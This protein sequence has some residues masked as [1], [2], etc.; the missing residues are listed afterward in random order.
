VVDRRWGRKVKLVGG[1]DVCRFFEQVHQFREVEELRKARPCPVACSLRRKLNGGC[2][3]AK[4]RCP[5]VKVR[6]IAVAERVMLQIAH[7]GEQLRHGV[8]NRR[9]GR[10]HNA[11]AAGDLVNIAALQ[12]HIRGFLRIGGGKTCDVAHFGVKEQILVAVCLVYIEPVNAKLL[13]CDN[14]ILAVCRLQF[15]KPQLQASLCPL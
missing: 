10:K 5:A 4:G 1:L 11:L 9:A 6:Q 15:L 12:K 14:I 8:G 2:C 7:H 13:E 3:F